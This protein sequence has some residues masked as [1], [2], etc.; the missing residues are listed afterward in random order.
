MME[1]TKIFGIDLGNGDVKTTTASQDMKYPSGYSVLDIQP[2]EDDV[3]VIGFGGKWYIF[4]EK[5]GVD[6]DKCNDERMFIS[7]LPAI[8]QNML[9][10]GMDTTRTQTISLAVGQTIEFFDRDRR[11]YAEYYKSRAAEPVKVIYKGREMKFK[12]RQDEEGVYVFPQGEVIYTSHSNELKEV[13][14]FVNMIEIGS[15]TTDVTVVE[16]Y[17]MDKAKCFSVDLATNELFHRINHR[18][19]AVT[20]EDI[21]EAMVKNYITTGRITYGTKET[22]EFICKVIQEEIEGFVKDILREMKKHRVNSQ[23]PTIV[24]GGGAILLWDYLKEE[25]NLAEDD[26]GDPIRFDEYENA[27]SFKKCALLVRRLMRRKKGSVA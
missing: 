25:F 19:K 22:K 12:V 21:S 11:A 4:N 15:Q 6:T 1:N 5:K 7:T 27:R 3:P 13:Y 2:E 20:R 18:Q 17:R 24:C 9:D 14:D 16:N 10:S 26:N 8:C 23:V